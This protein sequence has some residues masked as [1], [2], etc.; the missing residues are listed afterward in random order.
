M[1]FTHSAKLADLALK[2][3]LSGTSIARGFA[4]AGGAISYGPNI[5]ETSQRNAVQVAKILDGAKPGD[6]PIERPNKFDF[7]I[8]MK[9]VKALGLKVPTSLLSIA[10]QVGR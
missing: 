10:E 8:N 9:T 6:L 7:L 3:R 4:E 5:V 1:T 2:Y